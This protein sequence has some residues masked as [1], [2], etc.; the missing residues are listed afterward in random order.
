[1]HNQVWTVQSVSS[2][3]SFCYKQ[4][5]L[6]EKDSTRASVMKPAMQKKVFVHMNTEIFAKPPVYLLKTQFYFPVQAAVTEEKVRKQMSI[7][8]TWRVTCNW[9]GVSVDEP[10]PMGVIEKCNL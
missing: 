8:I 9:N 3:I 7:S 1:M 6:W 4:A 10:F 2:R 5:H